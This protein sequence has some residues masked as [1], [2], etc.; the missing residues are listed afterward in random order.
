[1]SQDTAY[2]TAYQKGERFFARSNFPLAKKEFEKAIKDYNKA[3]VLDPEYAWAYFNLARTRTAEVW[4]G[5]SKNPK[6]SI[7][8]A[9]KF[10]QKAIALDDTF[11]EPHA[12]LGYLFS[13][14]RKHEKALAEGIE[15]AGRQPVW[16]GEEL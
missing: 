13:M 11:A 2:Q 5:V 4:F 6:Q 12:Y 14:A 16:E 15:I 7:T 3:I 9:M 1:M 8:E 10:L